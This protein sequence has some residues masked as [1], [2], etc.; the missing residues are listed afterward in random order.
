MGG[1]F[2]IDVHDL[3]FV[4]LLKGLFCVLLFPHIIESR[5]LTQTQLQ[6]FS[7]LRTCIFA[8][9]LRLFKEETVL[10]EGQS[11]SR[12]LDLYVKIIASL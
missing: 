7:V 5:M 10:C 2:I 4:K 1:H 9:E 6:I 8:A 11:F 3:V 12:A